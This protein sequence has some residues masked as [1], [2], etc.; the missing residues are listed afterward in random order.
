[1]RKLDYSVIK[2]R[3]NIGEIITCRYWYKSDEF[4]AQAYCL[5][6]LARSGPY[7]VGSALLE[8]VNQESFT[9]ATSFVS[10]TVIQ[11][12]RVGEA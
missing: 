4:A 10:Q 3:Q 11:K 2:F 9:P 6:I 12:K 7:M 8:A 5:N 1:M